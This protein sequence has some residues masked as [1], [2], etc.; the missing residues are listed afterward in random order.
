[1]K[2]PQLIRYT[3]SGIALILFGIF[4]ISILVHA[5]WITHY[6]NF[7]NAVLRHGFTKQ[8]IDLVAFFTNIGGVTFL[9]Y[10]TVIVVLIFLFAKQYV[11]G[12]WFGMT[13]LVGAAIIPWLLKNAI[14]RPRP[15]YKLIPEH[16]YSFPS[17]H[18]SG[19]TIFYGMLAICLLLFIQKKWA[20]WT[21]LVSSIA[22]ILLIMC[23]RVYLGVHY[24]SDITA[25]CLYGLVIVTISGNELYK[26]LQKR[27]YL[28]KKNR[29]I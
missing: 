26:Y 5:K 17:G 10:L 11:V 18:S 12:I 22:L 15:E 28:Y 13:V 2:K 23:S 16:G 29:K 1:M 27:P 9:S 24:F 7:G 8:R 14:K 3:I 6:D 25:G 21:I 19:S 20:R 4:L